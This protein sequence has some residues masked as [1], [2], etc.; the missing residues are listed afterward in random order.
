MGNTIKGVVYKCTFANNKIYIGQTRRPLQQRIKEHVDPI[1]GPRT[2][3]FWK[4]YQENGEPQYEVLYETESENLEALV[5]DLNRVES[6]MIKRFK[7]YDEHYGYNLMSYGQ[8]RTGS[9]KEIYNLYMYLTSE[10][11][12]VPIQ[13]YNNIISKICK[14][15]EA[16]TEEEIYLVKEKYRDTNPHQKQIDAFDFKDITSNSP[17][18]IEMMVDLYLDYIH[19]MIENEVENDV[20]RFIE[21]NQAKIQA[22]LK[23]C[24]TIVQ[25]DKEGHIINEYASTNEICHKLNISSAENIRCVLRG[26]QKTA[27]GYIW[28]YKIDL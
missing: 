19:F 11:K 22:Y 3:G 20:S 26:K 27:Y 9:R 1:A 25:L 12:K 23:S 8:V 2:M 24:K 17:E 14:T 18:D 16:L 15:K 5:N 28:K 10:I 4:A 13:T 7:S 6:L 21:E